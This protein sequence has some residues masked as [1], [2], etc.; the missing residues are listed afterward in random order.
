LGAVDVRVPAVVESQL[1]VSKS[2]HDKVIVFAP[3]S[4]SPA[5]KMKRGIII[6]EYDT[7]VV[8]VKRSTSIVESGPELKCSGGPPHFAKRP[9]QIPGVVTLAKVIS[10]GS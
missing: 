8:I 2:S 4:V 5:T 1:L 7:G 3:T 6:G 9:K 10:I